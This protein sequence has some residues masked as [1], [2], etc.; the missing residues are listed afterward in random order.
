MS[1]KNFKNQINIQKYEI[2][3]DLL[4]YYYHKYK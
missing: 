4:R 3:S 1:S 2:I